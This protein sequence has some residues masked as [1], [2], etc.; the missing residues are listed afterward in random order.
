MHRPH[1]GHPPPPGSREDAAEQWEEVV[2][3][4]DVGRAVVGGQEAPA[5][6][7]TTRRR[8]PHAPGRVGR[9]DDLVV[10]DLVADDLDDS[11]SQRLVIDGEVLA[12]GTASVAVVHDEHPHRAAL[13]T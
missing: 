3:V 11:P 6:A 5:P 8:R 7:P 13:G 1:H 4:H 10:A 9:G 2:H 12:R